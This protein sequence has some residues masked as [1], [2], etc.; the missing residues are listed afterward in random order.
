MRE[1]TSRECRT[2]ERVN[3]SPKAME[4]VRTC[5]LRVDHFSRSRS[6]VSN[7]KSQLCESVEHARSREDIGRL[8]VCKRP[9]R[10]RY[11]QKAADT[12]FIGL[13]RGGI[14]LTGGFQQRTSRLSLLKR[15]LCI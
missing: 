4:R 12:V 8:S 7:S 3:N 2:T 6:L 11:I 9:L 5:A 14:R 15:R 10:S 13:K 1:S